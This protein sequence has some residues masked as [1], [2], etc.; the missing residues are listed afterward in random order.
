MTTTIT[1]CLPFAMS[2]L[3]VSFLISACSNDSSPTT[4]STTTNS[5]ARFI[6]NGSPYANVSIDIRDNVNGAW[7][8]NSTKR[9]TG[10]LD[11]PATFST[12][13]IKRT[14]FTLTLPEGKTGTFQ[15][16]DA[17]G[18]V[19]SESGVFIDIYDGSTRTH[20]LQAMSGTTR[21]T[22]FGSIGDSIAGTFSG[23]LRLKETGDIIS[24]SSGSFTFTR[25]P[26]N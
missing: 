12:G 23:T 2:A 24:L 13:S 15:W 3:F 16:I 20:T 9:V 7:L 4:P 5:S 18:G 19:L 11:A 10:I 26:N 14:V 8:D 6:L 21:V 17:K 25:L 1:R 22:V